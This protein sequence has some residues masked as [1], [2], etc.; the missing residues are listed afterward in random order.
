[1]LRQKTCENCNT[2]NSYANKSCENCGAPFELSARLKWRADKESKSP[3]GKLNINRSP[4]IKDKRKQLPWL[5]IGVVGFVLLLV[6]VGIFYNESEEEPIIA[7]TPVPTIAQDKVYEWEDISSE[8]HSNAILANNKYENQT[9]S[10]RGEIDEIDYRIKAVFTGDVFGP[11]EEIPTVEFAHFS[12]GNF[13]Y[14]LCGLENL[15][16]VENL[17]AGD[18]V[19]V[20]GRLSKWDVYQIRIYPCSIVD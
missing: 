8:F 11:I 14:L 4:D 12:S 16:E 3:A 13:S 9:I 7:T 17:S 20:N 1:M 15:D 19:I 5:L 6:L 18:T 10:I 2:R